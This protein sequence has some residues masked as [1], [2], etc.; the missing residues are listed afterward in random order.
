MRGV[1]LRGRAGRAGDFKASRCRASAASAAACRCAAHSSSSASPVAAQ[2]DRERSSCG[3]ARRGSSTTCAWLRSRPS[4]SRTIALSSARPSRRSLPARSP[5]P[6]CDLLRRGL[7]M[8]AGDERD[9]LDLLGIEA[10]QT[11]VLD[12]V[13]RVLV[14]ALVAD[15]RADVVQERAELEPLALAR[16]EAV[17]VAR[18]VEERQ[19]QPRDLL[20]VRRQS[21]CTARR[22]RSRCGAGRRD[23]ARPS[24]CARVALDV[25][26]HQALAQREVAERDLL[27]AEP[28]EQRVDEHDAGRRQVGAPRIE[29]RQLQPLA[30]AS[31]PSA[32]RAAR[33]SALARDA[34]VAEVVGRPARRRRARRARGSC[35]TCR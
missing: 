30:R 9:D 11:A 2:P 14:V 6:S 32:A 28:F 20:R 12:Q 18:R 4:A 21:S 5:K 17:R 31:W 35:P 33:R 29:V 23:S 16:A 1:S 34:D 25:V 15:V 7:A 13:V 22:A 19:R 27:G 3:R 10:A 26:E 24:G 8:V